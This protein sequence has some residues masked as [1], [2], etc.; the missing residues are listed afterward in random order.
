MKPFLLTQ[1]RQLKLLNICAYWRLGLDIA[2]DSRVR[3]VNSVAY[4]TRALGLHFVFFLGVWPIKLSGSVL[5]TCKHET[6][7]KQ[8][9]RWNRT[10]QPCWTNAA[11]IKTNNQQQ[12]KGQRSQKAKRPKCKSPQRH[13]SP[14]TECRTPHSRLKA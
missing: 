13:Q 2:K 8:D 14:G 4:K 10:V 1:D 6:V 3:K 7:R 9:P 12:T 5:C 11:E